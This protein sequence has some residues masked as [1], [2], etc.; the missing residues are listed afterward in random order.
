MSEI[1]KAAVGATG[2]K[3]VF[4]GIDLG[5]PDKV[6]K[7]V[8]IQMSLLNAMQTI[9]EHKGRITKFSPGW[10]ARAYEVVGKAKSK[11]IVAVFKEEDKK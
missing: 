7:D 3:L 4:G 11:D 9:M 8:P 10:L 5:A 6:T 1:D 2:K